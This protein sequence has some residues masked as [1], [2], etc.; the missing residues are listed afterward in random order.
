MFLTVPRHNGSLY[1][2]F[3]SVHFFS[4]LASAFGIRKILQR[5][6]AAWLGGFQLDFWENASHASLAFLASTDIFPAGTLAGLRVLDRQIF[7]RPP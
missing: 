2:S 5:Q 1:H 7:Q 4:T 6:H 3:R